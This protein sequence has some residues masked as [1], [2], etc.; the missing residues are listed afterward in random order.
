[1]ALGTQVGVG[2][3]LLPPFILFFF[4]I[5][6]RECESGGEWQREGGAEREGEN[7]KQ[8]PTQG[9]IP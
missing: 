1:M 4:L 5:L 7:P 3:A 9:S 2:G 8:S 6:Q